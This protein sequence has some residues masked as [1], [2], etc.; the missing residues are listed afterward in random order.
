MDGNCTKSPVPNNAP[1]VLENIFTVCLFSS[2]G[3]NI[4]PQWVAREAERGTNG[5]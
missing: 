1:T 5:R 4:W 3:E 2:S